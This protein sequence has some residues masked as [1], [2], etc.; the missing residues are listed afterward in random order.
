LV[1]DAKTA[2]DTVLEIGTAANQPAAGAGKQLDAFRHLEIAQWEL[3]LHAP[4]SLEVY[5]ALSTSPQH[6]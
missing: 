3:R 1:V 4:T 2:G 5:F 6:F